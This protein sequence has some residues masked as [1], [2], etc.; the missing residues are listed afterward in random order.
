MTEKPLKFV[1]LESLVRY[2]ISSEGSVPAYKLR[3]E[4]ER[5]IASGDIRSLEVD[6]EAMTAMNSFGRAWEMEE[7]E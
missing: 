1:E 3:I 4:I 6:E 7:E 5:G 2:L